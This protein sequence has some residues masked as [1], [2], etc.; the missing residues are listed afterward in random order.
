M[1]NRPPVGS[2]S[3]FDLT[4]EN[5]DEVR[6]FYRNVVGWTET[7][8]DMGGYS[9]HCMNQPGDGKTVAGICHARGGNAGLPAQ[10]LL[11]I[12]VADLDESLKQ[13]EAGGGKVL[14]GPLSYGAQGRYAIIQDPAG[15]AAALYQVTG[16]E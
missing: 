12:I 9:D 8:L 7:P 14:R 13:C 11:Y 4:V 5:A 3:W 15:A 10:W 6:A 2:I 1:S 16:A